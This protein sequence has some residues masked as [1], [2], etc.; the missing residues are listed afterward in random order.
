MRR[1]LAIFEASLGKDHP[2]VA[3]RLNNLAL[4]LH[5][6]NRLGEAEPLMRRALAIFFDFQR[7]HPH[8][9]PHRDAAI[10][11]YADLL[12]AMGQGE[13]EI[14]AAISALWREVA[15]NHHRDAPPY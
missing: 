4:L 3:T 12:A 15:S 8:A 7:D 5:A 1:A 11:N 13:A 14:E 10:S 9:H 6:A 2:N